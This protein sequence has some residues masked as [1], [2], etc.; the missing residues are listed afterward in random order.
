MTAL[1]TTHPRLHAMFGD[2][3]QELP[4]AVVAKMEASLCERDAAA[5]QPLFFTV[6]DDLGLGHCADGEPWT[7]MTLS[8][9]R[10]LD[11]A[12]ATHSLAG[13]SAVMTVLHASH[14]ARE[15][16]GP[17]SHLRADVVDGLFRACA[18]LTVH[19]QRCLRG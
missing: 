14:L 10:A 15:E 2:A 7:E 4:S 19:A 5:Q 16:E 1:P 18:S 13:L 6:L 9:G 12:R 3:I 11:M 17:G 8:P